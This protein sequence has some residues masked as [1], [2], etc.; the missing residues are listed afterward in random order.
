M[1]PKET[2]NR[3]SDRVRRRRAASVRV[4][5]AVRGLWLVL[6]MVVGLAI[7]AAAAYPDRPI[8][9]F[10]PYPPGGPNDVVARLVA[11][12]L[13]SR[14]GWQVVVEN[15]PGGSGHLALMAAAR[16]P[17]DGYT[18]VLPGIPYA[19]DPSL[20]ANVGYTFDQFAPV[21]IVTKGPLVLVVHPSLGVRSV[22]ELIALARSRPG[23]IDYGAGTKG[24]SLYLAAELFKYSATVDLQ[25]IPYNG[26]N[27]LIPDMLTG[28]VPVVFLSPLIAKQHV[29]AGRVLAL[30][31]TSA[32]RSPGWPDTPTIAE[33]GVPGYA[34]ETWYAVLAP[35]GTPKDIIDKLSGAIAAAVRSPDLSA[36]LES[37]GNGPVG[38]TAGEAATYIDVEAK[39]WRDIINSGG[40]PR[41]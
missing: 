28:R 35:K 20:F 27:D 1:R 23:K 39:R 34:M 9:L 4:F 31:I 10:V 30:G 6:A 18:L 16:A 37:L 24:T 3:D 8:H 29:A 2:S 26:T 32:Q 38:S 7:P 15:R 17:A 12:A 33:A 22:R 41:E 21:S 14:F 5:A 19:V 25:H 40:I 13:E 11:D 36:K